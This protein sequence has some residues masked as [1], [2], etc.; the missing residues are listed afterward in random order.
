V[1]AKT[2]L[3]RTG[4]FTL[5]TVE[6]RCGDS[7]WSPPE[8]ATAYGIVFV[9]RGCF[10]RRVNGA[11]SFVDSTVVYFERPDDEQQIA[12]P[13]GGDSCT[14]LYLSD[15]IL[16]KLWGGEPGLPDEPLA[17]DATTD[18]AQRLLL[19]VVLRGEAADLDEAAVDLAA[20]V[21]ERSAPKRVAAGRPTTRQARRRIVVGA[22]EAL[23]ENP[24]TG[25][26]EL[27]RRL[28][29]SPHHL[30]RIFRAETGETISRYRN[31][32]RVRLALERLAPGEPSL[33]RVAA[34]LGFADQ[35]H[36]ARVVRRELGAAPSSLRE[37]LGGA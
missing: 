19:A 12:H 30:S 25:V 11:E 23:V 20:R 14:V 34:E 5:E 2:A 15:E 27:A 6:C 29:V 31:R 10:R 21:L 37:R 26:T 32:L 17:S 13:G 1:I 22:R 36:L 24:R 28:A 35:A 18:L 16:A 4:D 8:A 33:A 9:R 7:G 3:A